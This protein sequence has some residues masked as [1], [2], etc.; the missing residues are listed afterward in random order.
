MAIT[1]NIG[2]SDKS[3]EIDWESLSVEQQ[4]TSQVD[5]C[6][7]NLK[8]HAGKTYRP[9][10]G[11]A[12]LVYDGAVSIFGGTITRI[13]DMVE[14]GLLTRLT[15]RC[16]SH[17]HT[18]DRYLVS[19]EFATKT[20]RYILNAILDDFVNQPGK[21]IDLMEATESWTTEDGAAAGDTTQGE[22]IE[23]NRSLKLTA[24]ASNTATVRRETTL[25]LTTF[26]DGSASVVGDYIKVYFYLPSSTDYNN[27]SKIRIR[28]GSDAAAV[29]TNYFEYEFNNTAL[30]PG[31]YADL[32]SGWFEKLIAKSAFTSVGAPDWSDI[33]KRQ[34]R[35][36]A[37]ASGTSNVVI[38]DARLISNTRAFFGGG[39]SPDADERYFDLKF[40]YEQASQAIKQMAEACGCDWY[41][42]PTRELYFFAPETI[43]A[44][45]SLID[46]SANFLWNS[47]RFNSDSST[48]KNTIIVRGG[49][50]QGSSTTYSVV[51]DGA[52]KAIRSPYRL[53]NVTVTLGGAAQTVGIDNIDDPAS[54]NCLYN[55]QEKTLKFTVT[56][57]AG[58]T[59]AITGNPMIPVIIKRSDSTSVAANGFLV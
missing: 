10:V 7:F 39:I 26:S 38:D 33:K 24:T 34:Y 54:Y 49:E 6:Y 12:V 22:Y 5:S 52:I 9:A 4:L 30:T 16:V 42:D 50:Y 17:E 41:I 56:P 23:G 45:Y 44:P 14:A 46:S 59:V 25:D 31:I 55:Y 58:V 32:T 43:P 37:K 13:D 19:H 28:F 3:S 8:V 51:A 27:L 2:G 57:G 21:E 48:I 40:N 36:T 35:I 20:P 1:I 15:V 29:Y 18:L 53:K 11:D 47:L